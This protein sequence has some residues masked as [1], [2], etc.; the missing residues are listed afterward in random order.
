MTIA[1]RSV[2]VCRATHQ[3]TPL[4]E[5]L[6]SLGAIPVHV[7]LIEVVAPL[8]GGDELRRLLRAAD[9]ATWLAFTSANSVDAVAAALEGEPLIS[10][11]AAVGGATSDRARSLG[12][13]VDH[14]PVVATAT[15]LATSLPAGGRVIAPLGELA[16]SDLVD[17][18]RS[19]GIEVEAVTAYRTTT[20]DV[21]PVDT[22]RVIDSD[23][24][25][26]TA[27]SVIRR[28]MHLVEV[29]AFDASKLPPLVAIGPTSSAAIRQAG[30]VVADEATHPSMDGL[31]DA[32]VRTLSP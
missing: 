24:V 4:L 32:V 21:S 27:P 12:W 6:A 8:D 9:E 1:G 11:V 3:A 30:L 25:L 15:G 5:R 7:P 13:P 26:V 18:L 20:P 10:R 16:S 23:A 19:R 28:L 2:V 17:G 22:Q 29:A 31:I 14:V